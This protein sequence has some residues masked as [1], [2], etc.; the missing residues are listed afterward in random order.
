MLVRLPHTHTQ[1]ERTHIRRTCSASVIDSRVHGTQ[2]S[3]FF[4]SLSFLLFRFGSASHFCCARQTLSKTNFHML[5]KKFFYNLV[6]CVSDWATH[7]PRSTY[8]HSCLPLLAFLWFSLLKGCIFF[9]LCREECVR[10]CYTCLTLFLAG[11]LV[12][13]LQFVVSNRDF[14]TVLRNDNIAKCE[15]EFSKGMSCGY[16]CPFILHTHFRFDDGDD[17]DIVHLWL[18]PLNPTHI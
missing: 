12:W 5:I 10:V 6:V 13:F 18:S 15:I 17:D 11:M 14:C 8:M 4:F 9:I 2:F 3:L 7:A 16:R 1:V